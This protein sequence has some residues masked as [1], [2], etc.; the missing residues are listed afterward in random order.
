MVAEVVYV[1]W[2][3]EGREDDVQRL[4]ALHADEEWQE[5]SS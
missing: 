4:L 2:N 1:A 5:G 3:G